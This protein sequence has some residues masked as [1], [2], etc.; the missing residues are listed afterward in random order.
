MMLATV[1]FLLVRWRNRIGKNASNVWNLVPA[2]LMVEEKQNSHMFEDVE[3][4][5][6][7]LKSL[8][9]HTLFD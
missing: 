8:L 1:A 6:D 3:R 4:P 5:L 9:I 7:Q 2:C